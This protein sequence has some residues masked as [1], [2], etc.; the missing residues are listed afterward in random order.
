MRGAET[1]LL[2]FTHRSPIFQMKLSRLP[3]AFL[4]FFGVQRDFSSDRWK[5]YLRIPGLSASLKGLAGVP[6]LPNQITC[7]THYTTSCLV[8]EEQPDMVFKCQAT[9]G[10]EQQDGA[11][12]LESVQHS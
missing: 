3:G 4:F 2:L 12:T 8:D 11:V 7:L 5:F 1:T 10:E 9:R 6:P